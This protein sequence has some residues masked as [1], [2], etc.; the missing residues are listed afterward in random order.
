MRHDEIEV[1]VERQ[2]DALPA[3]A[4]TPASPSEA[5][6]GDLFKRLSTDTSELI[7]QE[8]ALAKAEMRE[9]ARGLAGD[10]MKVGVAA[11]LALVGVLALSAFVIL[12]LGHLL[13]DAF[14]LSS[15]IVGIVALGVGVMLGRSAMNDIRSRG[16]KPEQTI[17]TLRAD[18]AWAGQQ[19]RELKQD[20]TTDPTAPPPTSR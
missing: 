12:A 7:R 3:S 4:T 9:M 18:K 10:A 14:W 11:G 8:A 20:L 6:L 19:A 17:A 1:R 13:G 15:L 16:L 5:S 2:G